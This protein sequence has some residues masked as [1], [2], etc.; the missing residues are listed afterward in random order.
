MKLSSARCEEV[1]QAV[2]AFTRLSTIKMQRIVLNRLTMPDFTQ[3]FQIVLCTLFKPVPLEEFVLHI[4]FGETELQF[5]LNAFQCF[6]KPFFTGHEEF[7]RV[8]PCFIQIVQNLPRNGVTDL[9]VCNPIEIEPNAKRVVTRRHPHVENLSS[10]S[11]FATGKVGRGSSVLECNQF[12]NE[13]LWVNLLPYVNASMMFKKRLW[14]VQTVYA[15]YRGDNHTIRSTNEAC[16]SSKPFLFDSFVDRH[17]FIDVQIPFCKICFRL[18]IVVMRDKVI[19]C[20]FWKIACNFMVQLP[21]QRFV[22]AEDERWDIQSFNHV[23][24]SKGLAA[25]RNSEQNAAFL[26]IFQL[27]DKR[28]DSAGLVSRWFEFTVQLKS[29]YRGV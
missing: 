5:I 22:V 2:R 19:D 27:L 25:S 3:H 28:I 6:L 26:P 24:H 14:W 18:V 10:Q 8:N 11:T 23:R 17:F 29:F 9:H 16:N 4:E 21:R 12:A 15:G 13:I 20:I 7:F 1:Q